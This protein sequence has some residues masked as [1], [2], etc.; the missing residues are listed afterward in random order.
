MDFGQRLKNLRLERGYTQQDL[1]S[2]VGVSTVAV[3]SWEHNT[4]KAEHGCLDCAWAFSEHID[5]YAS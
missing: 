2:A 5:R 4:K 1:S 3:R